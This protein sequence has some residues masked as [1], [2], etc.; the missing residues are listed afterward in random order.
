MLCYKFTVH[1]NLIIGSYIQVNVCN[2]KKKVNEKAKYKKNNSTADY[3]YNTL[4]LL[5]NNTVLIKTWPGRPRIYLT[6]CSLLK[7]GVY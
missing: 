5:W 1:K 2:I 3:W 4:Y 6:L 7:P